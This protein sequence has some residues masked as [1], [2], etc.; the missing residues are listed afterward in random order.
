[1]TSTDLQGFILTRHWRDA[2]A[3]TEIEYWLA[4]DAGP[5]KVLLTARSSVAFVATRSGP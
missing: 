1:M 2:S 5:L 3:G 4:T